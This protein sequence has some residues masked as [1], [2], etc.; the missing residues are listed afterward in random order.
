M[1]S[2][3]PAGNLFTDLDVAVSAC[4]ANRGDVIVCMEGFSQ[5]VTAI[6][7]LDLD[8]S[9]ITIVFLG[10]GTTQANITFSTAEGADMD[11]D[12]ANITLIR[13]KFVAA[14]DALTGP[15]DINSTDF[16]I[17]DG[18]YHDAAGIETTDCIIAT[19]GA[20]RLM[21]DGW[22]FFKS[23]EAGTQKESHIQLNGVDDCVLR[24]L[25][26][27]GDFDTGIIENATDEL[28]RVTFE[29]FF[30]KNTDPGNGPCIVLDSA[31]SGWA[32][33]VHLRN[34]NGTVVSDNSD[35]NWGANC[36]GFA[37]DGAAGDPIGTA[38]SGGVEGQVSQAVSEIGS[39]G[40]KA[41]T[42]ISE[43]GSV[44][45]IASSVLSEVGSVGVVASGVLSEV[46]SVG[47]LQ[48]TAISEVGSVG[49]LQSTAISEV[50]SVGVL[51]STAISEVGSVGVIQ[52]TALS[53]IGSVGVKAST[54]ISTLGSLATFMSTQ[55]SV[56]DSQVTA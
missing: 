28:L 21:I 55:F 30:L 49:V 25:N 24:N 11:V 8:V 17:I 5:A 44:G 9:G 19:S 45:V 42:A 56:I 14:I 50:G 7:G 31:C 43:V 29:N 46:G 16:K 3:V 34:T 10:S 26:I 27:E 51:Q 6:G 54:I 39:V 52:S 36:L 35:I 41:S 33:N 53:E 47:V 4:V 18:E 20:T 37:A 48:S 15:I 38:A 1:R 40:V 13:P 22:K 12:A 2:R 23:D 32:K